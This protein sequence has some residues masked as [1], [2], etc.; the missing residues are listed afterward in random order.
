MIAQI[1][2]EISALEAR[3]AKLRD[4]RETIVS[5]EGPISQGGYH[6]FPVSGEADHHETPNDKS[7]GRSTA[8]VVAQPHHQSLRRSSPGRAFVAG[9]IDKPASAKEQ[10]LSVIRESDVALT[11]AEIR[12]RIGDNVRKQTIWAQLSDLTKNG[13]LKRSEDGKYTLAVND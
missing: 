1:D 3:I 4:A 6:Q 2:A 5:L 10:I 9:L 13:V 8:K 12:D 7:I 11:S